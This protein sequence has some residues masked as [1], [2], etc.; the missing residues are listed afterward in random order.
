M[1]VPRKERALGNLIAQM[2]T[3]GELKD[4]PTARRLIKESFAIQKYTEKKAEA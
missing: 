1:R 3:S 2:I 4:L